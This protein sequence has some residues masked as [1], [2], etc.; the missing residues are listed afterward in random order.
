M[1]G[2]ERNDRDSECLNH[3]PMKGTGSEVGQTRGGNADRPEVPGGGCALEVPGP[4]PQALLEWRVWLVARRPGKAIGA[5]AIMLAASCL[6]AMGTATVVLGLAALV[7]LLL[8]TR[9][10]FLP[11]RYRLREE[12]AYAEW[13]MSS[14]FISWGKVKRYDLSGEGLK[15]SPFGRSSRLEPFRGVYLRFA[16]NCEEVVE[17]V[18]VLAKEAHT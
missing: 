13:F 3:A 5:L 6:I 11:V 17:M 8:A 4:S 1:T 7:L 10:F 9:E 12:G 15:L 18:K 14:Y 2:F 16:D